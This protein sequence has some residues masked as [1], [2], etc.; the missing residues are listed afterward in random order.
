VDVLTVQ[1]VSME[2]AADE[3]HLAR[4]MTEGRV[5]VTQDADFLA[6]HASGVAHSG[7]AYA[8]QG[9]PIGDMVRGLMIFDVLTP[10]E[11]SNQLEFL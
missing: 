7:I 6:L 8:R 1:D 3:E 2:L 9:T 4:A 11:M 5:L 10:G